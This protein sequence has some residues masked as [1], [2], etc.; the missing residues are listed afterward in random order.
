VKWKKSKEHQ[1]WHCYRSFAGNTEDSLGTRYKVTR[2]SKHMH[3]VDESHSDQAGD[4][5]LN[6]ERG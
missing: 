1:T 5:F 3:E 4:R 6:G 2:C